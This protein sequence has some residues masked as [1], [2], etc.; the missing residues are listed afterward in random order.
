MELVLVLQTGEAAP[1]AGFRDR[2]RVRAA[3]VRHLDDDED[4]GGLGSRDRHR[5]GAQRRRDNPKG[6]FEYERVKELD[7]GGDK[8]WVADHRGKV[9]KIISFLLKDLPDD[10]LYKVIFMRRNLDEVL[11]SQNKMLVRRGE[12]GGQAGDEEMKRLYTNHLGKVEMMFSS[13]PNFELLDVHYRQVVENPREQA[14][15]VSRFLELSNRA[16]AM[17]GAVDRQLYRNRRQA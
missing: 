6:Y 2:G 17:A 10:N 16:E 15:R 9:V 1:Q 12:Q 7:K 5:C 14:A 8:N 3:A 13:K 4:A 11:A